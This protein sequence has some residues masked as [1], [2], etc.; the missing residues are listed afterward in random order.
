MSNISRFKKIVCPSCSENSNIVQ[1][2]C[3]SDKYENKE[4]TK[5]LDGRY[6]IYTCLDCEI[7][8]CS[9]ISKKNLDNYYKSIYKDQN[10]NLKP[11][12]FSEFNS[13]FFSQV[14][15]F[16]N[17]DKLKENLNVLELGP[18]NQGVLPTLRI[19]QKKI[20]YYYFEQN[21]INYNYK[22][23]VKLGEYFDPNKSALPKVDLIWISH[24]LEHIHPDD[25]KKMLTCFYESLNIGG[26][27]FIEIPNEFKSKTLY[28]PHTLFFSKKGLCKLFENN[29]FHIIAASEIYQSRIEKQQKYKIIIKKKL[30][31][32]IYLFIQNIY[33]F[34]QNFLPDNFVKKF[35]FR[36]FVLN[37]PTVN[38]QILRVIVE[39]R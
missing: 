26:K 1:K 17:H 18:N 30:I 22:N 10:R 34:I 4:V 9:G 33:L 35:A 2:Y 37:G 39:K 6:K 38:S 27:I 24:S 23:M 11:S 13:R 25:L 19:F 8:F 31:Q 29:H 3:Y 21:N 16:I 15:F 5:Y 32:K 36:N 20:N 12:R 14:L 28:F 7:S